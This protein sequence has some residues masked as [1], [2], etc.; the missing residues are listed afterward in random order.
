[1]SV[2]VVGIG[3]IGGGGIAQG[4]HLPAYKKLSDEGKVKIVAVADANPETAK[5]AA[6]KFGIELQFTDYREMLKLDTIDAVDICTPNFLHAKPTVDALNAGK[7]VLVEKPIALNA[8]EGQSMVDAARKNGKKLQVALNSRFNGGPQAIKRFIKDGRLGDIYYARA[9]ALRRR[10]VPG[11]GVFTQKDKQGGGPLID[12]GVHILDLTLWLMDYPEPKSVS[13][14][15]YTK[16]GTREGVLGL[17]GQWDPKTYTVEDFAVGL[18][19][20]KNGATLVLESSFIANIERDEMRTHVMGTEGGAVLDPFNDANTKIFREESG[21]LTD[22]QP[23][24][25]PRL[26]SHELEIRSFVKAI[27]EDTE[28][29]VP[30]EQGLMVTRILDGIYASSE[31]GKEIVF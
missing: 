15:S 14:T 16:F 1:M 28:V 17:M 19:K 5:T 7:H 24:F 6:E 21:S 27:I 4:A 18:V 8:V 13:G 25:L 29:E 23:V 3:I 12:I 9:H 22:S 26:G 31:Q 20:F 11:W 2:N 30:G 10:G